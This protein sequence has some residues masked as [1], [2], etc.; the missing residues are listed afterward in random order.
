M[1]K[2]VKSVNIDYEIR[3]VRST[4]MEYFKESLGYISK[5]LREGVT[6]MDASALLG[7][8]NIGD[9]GITYP[10]YF[11]SKINKKFYHSM[12][13]QWSR[14]ANL[15][16]SMFMKIAEEEHLYTTPLILEEMTVLKNGIMKRIQYASRRKASRNKHKDNTSNRSL[17][18]LMKKLKSKISSL[19]SLIKVHDSSSDK[20][21][22]GILDD[23]TTA[24]YDKFREYNLSKADLELLLSFMYASTNIFV[25]GANKTNDTNHHSKIKNKINLI[26]KDKGIIRLF[27]DIL[28][29]EDNKP[30]N[31]YTYYILPVNFKS[32]TKPKLNT[33]VYDLLKYFKLGSKVRIVKIFSDNLDDRSVLDLLN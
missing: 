9:V 20:D 2:D 26:C 25:D 17:P 14:Y 11:I 3:N 18:P 22:Q 15:Y 31:I 27:H 16:L 6:F 32:Y 21:L 10:N 33:N 24:G 1:K 4:A 29:V 19:I 12:L 23:D 13:L 30:K 28:K 8:S 7:F 5:T